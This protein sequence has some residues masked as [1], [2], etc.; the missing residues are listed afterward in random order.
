MR[1]APRVSAKKLLH[2]DAIGIKFTHA[3]IAVLHMRTPMF[4]NQAGKALSS[5]AYTRWKFPHSV[6]KAVDSI[7]VDFL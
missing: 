5:W 2:A 6:M 1:A 3:F 4:S 7:G